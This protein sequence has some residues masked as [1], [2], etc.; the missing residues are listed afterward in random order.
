MPWPGTAGSHVRNLQFH[1]RKPLVPTRGTDG[2][3]SGDVGRPHPEV[4]VSAPWCRL[5]PSVRR[6]LCLGDSRTDLAK[7]VQKYVNHLKIP[8]FLVR[9]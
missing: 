2:S 7:I 5:S 3:A 4:T 1:P 6:L 9:L 8:F